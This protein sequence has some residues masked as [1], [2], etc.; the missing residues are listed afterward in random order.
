MGMVAPQHVRKIMQA[1]RSRDTRPELAVRRMLTEL[2]FRYRLH[3]R[4]LPGRPDIV[5]RG[6]RKVILVHGCFWRI[7]A[8]AAHCA[9]TR[10]LTWRIGGLSLSA[11]SAAMHLLRPGF[12]REAGGCCKSGSAR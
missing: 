1:N 3:A 10:S 4:D 5:F 8:A 7:R 2:G 9:R 6:R 12:E 11:T